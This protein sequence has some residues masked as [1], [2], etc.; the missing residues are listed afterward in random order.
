[1]EEARWALVLIGAIALTIILIAT[2]RRDNG[3]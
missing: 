1:M 3:R 2:H